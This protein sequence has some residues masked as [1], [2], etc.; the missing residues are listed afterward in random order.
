MVYTKLIARQP[1]CKFSENSAIVM[2]QYKPAQN[3]PDRPRSNTKAF[4]LP[5]LNF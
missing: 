5:K 2:S 3:N 1:A 4:A